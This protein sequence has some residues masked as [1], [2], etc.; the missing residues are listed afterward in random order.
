MACLLGKWRIDFEVNDE[1]S[2]M[3]RHCLAATS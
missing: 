1:T 2:L 3:S